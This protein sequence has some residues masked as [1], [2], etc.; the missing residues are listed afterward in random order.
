MTNKERAIE[1]MNAMMAIVKCTTE[2]ERDIHDIS[3]ERMA[4]LMAELAEEA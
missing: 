2:E 4:D 1:L 3:L